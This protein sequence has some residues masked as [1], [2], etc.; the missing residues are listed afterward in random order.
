LQEITQGDILERILTY[1]CLW[2]YRV[3][4]WKKSI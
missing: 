2:W 1:W 3:S 4:L